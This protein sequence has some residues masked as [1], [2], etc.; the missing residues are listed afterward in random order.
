MRE[1]LM[2]MVRLC[3]SG[4]MEYALEEGGDSVEPELPLSVAVVRDGPLWVR[5]G[6][7]IEGADGAEYET[8]NRVTLCRCGAS[9]NKP[10][11]DGTHAEIGFTDPGV[12]VMRRRHDAA[13]SSPCSRSTPTGSTWQY[14]WCP[15][16][17]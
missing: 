5:G 6:I 1:R 13:G 7:P 9:A 17:S 8:R 14:G 4:A 15:L 2:A 11:C 10:Y 3:P 12:R 16:P